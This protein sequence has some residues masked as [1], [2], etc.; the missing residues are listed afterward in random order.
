VYGQEL[1]QNNYA[2]RPAID[3]Q[4]G[5]FQLM[6][7]YEFLKLAPQTDA[8][9]AES[10]FHGLAARIQYAA[11]IVSIGAQYGRLK[12]DAIDVRGEPDAQNSF[13]PWQSIGGYVNFRKGIHWPGL[14]YHYT[15]EKNQERLANG[16]QEG[17][18]QHQ[19]FAS[20]MIK[21]PVKGLA[22][23]F[24]YGFG[25]ANIQDLD[26][27]SEFH[28]VMQSGRIRIVYDPQRILNPQDYP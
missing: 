11:D 5:G 15:I 27:L 6:A 21:L 3:L 25:V 9:K 18:D 22:L 13:D 12:K 8:V 24:V 7:G 26:T 14:G 19:G 2:V 20:Y 10:K 28:N 23:K 1:N 4:Y 17:R 16:Q